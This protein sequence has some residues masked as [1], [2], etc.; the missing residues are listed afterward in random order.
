MTQ[1][2]ITPLMMSHYVPKNTIREVYGHFQFF[3]NDE[4]AQCGNFMIFLSFRFYVKSILG[5]VE[6]Q[7]LLFFAVLGDVNFVYY[8]I[9]AFKK[10][11]NPSKIK[12][13]CL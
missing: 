13:Q 11:K 4:I 1:Q 10:C 12:I 9:C 6:M 8:E 3:Q 5:I 7:K 2:M